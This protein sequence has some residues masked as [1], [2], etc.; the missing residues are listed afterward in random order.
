MS[1]PGT[2][3]DLLYILTEIA[4][5]EKTFLG[6]NFN[7]MYGI[8]LKVPV[9]IEF[10]SICTKRRWNDMNKL[11]KTCLII[12][13]VL[14]LIPVSG[15]AGG[16][17]KEEVRAA[18]SAISNKNDGETFVNLPSL[19]AP[20][21]AGQLTEEVLADARKTADFVRWLAGLG[22]IETLD[23]LNGLAQHGAAL[24]AAN[25]SLSH[26]PE[27]PEDM[28]DAFYD[29]AWT[30]ASSSNL[31]SFNWSEKGLL[32]EAVLQFVRDDGGHNREILGHRRWILYPG[33]RYT[34]FGFA[35]DEDGR[36]YAAMY[37]MDSS[38]TDAEYDLIRWPS[39]GAFPAEY[40]GMDTPWSVSPAPDV[41]DLNASAPRILLT[42]ETS[43]AVYVFEGMTETAQGEE[44]FVLGGG[45]YGDG[46][47]YIFHPDL[48]RYEQLAYGYQ[49]NQV[50]TV[51]LEGMVLAD[52]TAAEAAEYTVKMISL[53]P[54]APS[55]VEIMPREITLRAGE[56]IQL[57]AQ[58]I[59][60][61]ADDLTVIW[62]T[63]DEA[64]AMVS[65]TGVVTGVGAGECEIIAETVNG[66]D[67]RIRVTVTE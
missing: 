56:K 7:L 27:K 28:D 15:Q 54:I 42:E 29:T 55:A 16:H 39:A 36:S 62:R 47:A 24:M 64:V 32:S 45:R 66:R 9:R 20:Y 25:K 57:S 26:D 14:L 65:G 10:S 31:I 33:M 3:H 43:G 46:P 18:Y 19:T 12:L 11:Y 50:W 22:E 48:T 59:P 5:I 51:R 17:T 21:S 35:Q 2:H 67:D 61:W 41:Y 60:D 44:Y 63:E 1:M 23:R 34:G 30:A 49:Q 4:Q 38:R 13:L 58:V 8:F 52:G 40:M 6:R 37:V 53:E